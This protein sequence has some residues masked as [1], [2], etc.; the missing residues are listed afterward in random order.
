MVLAWSRTYDLEY[1]ILRPTNN[2][3]IG[4]YPEK[5]IP[6]SVKN[7][8]RGKKIR[9][10]NQGS[11]VRTWLHA[12][13]TA[14]AV[15]HIIENEFKNE[16][17]N[18]SGN[19]EQSNLITVNKILNNYFEEDNINPTKHIDLSFSRQGQ[20]VRYSLDDSKLRATGWKKKRD[21]DSEI[22]N[23]VSFYKNSFIW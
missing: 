11:P 7:L 19:Y 20:D 10:H 8:N 4:Q 3:G 2:Y 9:L 5:L 16:I 1:I 12:E 18:I 15:I 21:F 17:F 22:K 6:L 14:E 13:D 23:I